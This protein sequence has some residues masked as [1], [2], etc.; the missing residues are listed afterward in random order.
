MSKFLAEITELVRQ[1]TGMVLP[2]ARETAILAAV[3]RAAP[4]LGPGAFLRQASEPV[5]GRGLVD[6]LIDE[7]TVQETTF[8]RHRG[9]LDTVPWHGLLQGAHQAAS[10]T[11]RVWCAA[12]ASGEEAYTLALLADQAFAPEKA[13]VDVLGTDISG[14]A[15]AAAAAGRYSERAIRALEPALRSRYLDREAD[16]T[17]LVGQRLRELVRFRRHNLASDPFPPPGEAGF[18]LVACRNVLIYFEQPM[19][20]HVI[21]SLE[22]SLRPGGMLMLGAADALQRTTARPANPVVLARGPARVSGRQ[23]RR[24]LGRQPARPREERLAA[25]LHAAGKGDR[26]AALALVVSLL[27]DDPLDA[28]AHFVEGLVTLEAGEPARAAAALRRALYTDATFALA[29]FTL[30]RA[31][32]ELGDEP[33]AR[34]AYERVLRTLDPEDHRHEPILQQVD[35]GDIAAACRARLGGQP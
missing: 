13:P 20:G 17:Y 31:Y 19:V 3:D 12:C 26:D 14:A 7:V 32:D 27:A 21:E 4:G 16:G 22:R 8:V 2:A 23:L 34:R 24:P 11:V 28:D 5:Q 9:Q 1:E 29:A 33:A 15:L 10:R 6:R 18:D 35:I 25:A 30:G